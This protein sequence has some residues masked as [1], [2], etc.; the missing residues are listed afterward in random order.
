MTYIGFD[1]GTSHCAAGL[2]TAEGVRMAALDEGAPLLPSMLWAPDVR[3]DLPLDAQGRIRTDSDAFGALRF[4]SE[5]LADYLRAPSRGYFVKSPKSFLGAP[6]LLPVVRERFERVVGAMMACVRLRAERSLELEIR[7]AVI[8]RPVNFQGPVGAVENE[9]ALDMLRRAAHLAGFAEVSFLFEP[10][11]AAL[12]Y[13]ARL[14]R[15][16]RVLVVDVGGGTTDCSL[17]AVGPGH[18][19]AHD[20]EPDMLGHSGERLGGND[21]D[22]ALAQAAVVPQLGWQGALRSGLPVP[23]HYLVDAITINDV[24]AQARFYSA[25]TGERLAQLRDDALEPQGLDRLLA[26]QQGRGT[27]RLLREVEQ[28][29]IE[30]S[31][32]PQAGISLDFLE[33][34]L[35]VTAHRSQLDQACVRL[36]QRLQDA[37]SA[38]RSAQQS[39]DLVYLTGGMA[40]SPVV[41]TALAEVLGH[42]PIRDSDHF[43]SV[44]EGLALWARQRHGSPV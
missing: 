4:G 30:L 20:R 43:T 38:L 9:Q 10:L 36:R 12:E 1:Y 8:G 27:Y 40:Q 32:A 2:A 42:L 41:R 44:T 24:N 29:K 14:T 3:F 21:Y 28:A 18:R 35:A 37:V 5:A 7:G 6:G 19:T 13:E 26:L 31:R 16:E 34:G 33:Q 17:V 39:P 23:N 22:Q 15:N 25:G 11:A